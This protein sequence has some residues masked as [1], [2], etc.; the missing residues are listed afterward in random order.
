M[1]DKFQPFEHTAVYKAAHFLL[2]NVQGITASMNRAYK[3]TA[4]IKTLDA[5]IDLSVF[6]AEAYLEKD[7]SQKLK[8]VKLIIKQVHKVL[9]MLR[10]TYDL[11]L[12]R[13]PLYSE[14]ITQ[15]VDIIKQA[16]GWQNSLIKHSQNQDADILS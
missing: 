14:C 16:Q 10:V 4:G 12:V 3:Y 7:P 8:Q 6:I 13:R 1:T 9:I 11:Q 2:K 15:C 5:A